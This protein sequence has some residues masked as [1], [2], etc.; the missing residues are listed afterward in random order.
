MMTY[1]LSYT[2][3]QSNSDTQYT[4][5]YTDLYTISNMSTKKYTKIRSRKIL[6]VI[7]GLLIKVLY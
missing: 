1:I 5:Y 3:I 7:I 4:S 6:F 2:D